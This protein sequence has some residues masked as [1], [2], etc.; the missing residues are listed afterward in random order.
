MAR[1]IES[2]QKCC[3]DIPYTM[4]PR[5]N[6]DQAESGDPK[7]ALR[8]RVRGNHSLEPILLNGLRHRAKSGWAIDR[9]EVSSGLDISPLHRVHSLMT[10]KDL[11]RIVRSHGCLE[12]RQ[13]G[14]HVR[15]ECGKCVTTVPVHAGEDI[16]PGLLRRIERDL[17]R[18]LG[19]GWLKKS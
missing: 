18:C 2:R 5:S 17:E 12:K 14:S 15:I 19:K 11:R 9:C 7:T 10:A 13:R 1:A 3:A 16:G 4:P 8:K 6:L